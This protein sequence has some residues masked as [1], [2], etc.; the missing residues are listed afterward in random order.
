MKSEKYSYEY[1]NKIKH[2]YLKNQNSKYLKKE[3]KKSSK[4]ILSLKRIN[5][6]YIHY[7]INYL[8]KYKKKNSNIVIHSVM[9]KYVR[10]MNNEP[11][12]DYQEKTKFI[13]AYNK[14]DLSIWQQVVMIK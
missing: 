12:L 8:S 3:S 2:L 14:K 10:I 1:K 5:I 7:F 11:N 6:S 13:N 9:R 4:Y